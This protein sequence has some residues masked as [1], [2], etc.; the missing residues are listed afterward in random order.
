MTKTLHCLIP[1]NASNFQ[2]NFCISEFCT[3]DLYCTLFFNINNEMEISLVLSHKFSAKNKLHQLKEF[4]LKTAL[5]KLH[6][7]KTKSVLFHFSLV[8]QSCLFL[9]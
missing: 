6:G 5:E 2:L 3:K 1:L 8:Y 4:S 9:S 7:K